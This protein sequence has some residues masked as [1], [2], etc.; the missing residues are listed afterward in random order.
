[1]T[2]SLSISGGF[3]EKGRKH[4]PWL[5]PSFPFLLPL[6]QRPPFPP[7]LFTLPPTLPLSLSR[8]SPPVSLLYCALSLY[9]KSSAYFQPT[10][11][12]ALLPR[13]KQLPLL[14]PSMVPSSLPSSLFS[15]PTT[16][17]PPSSSSPS[18][19]KPMT[20]TTA[21]LLLLVAS[22][23]STQLVQAQKAGTFE[24]LGSSGVSAQQVSSSSLSSLLETHTHILHRAP[25]PSPWA[26]G[27]R[28]R[29][30]AGGGTPSSR[31]SRSSSSPSFFFSH[32]LTVLLFFTPFIAL[33]R[34]SQQ[35][36]RRR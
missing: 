36:L 6:H 15:L 19:R 23:A 17:T 3:C 27:R 21:L 32:L 2:N 4:L 9:R 33:S 35:G 31:S 34:R 20:P 1:M 7:S 8:S 18:P 11:S 5:R 29:K 14:L 24:V 30:R 26:G 16:T 12:V 13:N 10:V 28:G 25:R 22:S